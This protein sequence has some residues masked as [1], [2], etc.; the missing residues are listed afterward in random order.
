MRRR[1]AER[2]PERVARIDRV[3]FVGAYAVYAGAAVIW[4]VLGLVPALAAAFPGFADQLREWGEQDTLFGDMALQAARA[5][6]NSSSG[7]QV[8]LDYAFSTLNIALATFLVVKVRGNRTANLLAIGMVG[9]GRRVQPAVARRPGR[10]RHP[11]RR[12]HPALA[13]PRGPR[14]G[15]HRLRVRA[16]AVP[17]RLDRPHARA[18]PDGPGARSS[19]WSRS[20][21]SRITRAPSCCCSA[22]SCPA[23]ALLAHSRRFREAQSPELRQLYRLLGVAMGVSLA[24]AVAVLMVTSV[25]KSSDE[26]FT[27]T[28]A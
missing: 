14:P 12:V 19:A 24:G 5:A 1:A 27:E 9:H 13:R 25:L 11:A 20:S 7:V 23:A 26:R 21:R 2:S 18:A 10:H 15:R 28:H 16:A 3:A 22:C 17:R 8:T 6:R 4:L